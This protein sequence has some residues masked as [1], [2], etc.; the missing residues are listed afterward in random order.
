MKPFRGKRR[1]PQS[2]LRRI[3]SVGLVVRPDRRRIRKGHGVRCSLRSAGALSA[4]GAPRPVRRQSEALRGR[5]PVAARFDGVIDPG[6]VGLL[7]GPRKTMLTRSV[8]ATAV[9]GRPID[10]WGL[11]SVP[12][13]RG[14]SVVCGCPLPAWGRWRIGRLPVRPVLKHGPRSLTCARVSGCYET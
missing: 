4:D 12:A 7:G 6:G 8:A 14:R 3:Q 2:L 10:L 5:W 11:S 1:G 13:N 9:S